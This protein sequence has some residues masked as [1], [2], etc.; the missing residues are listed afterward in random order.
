MDEQETDGLP[1]QQKLAFAAR[2]DAQAAA[3]VAAYRYGTMLKPYLCSYCGL[4][5]LATDYDD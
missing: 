3:T 2:K 1:C 5:H 4:W